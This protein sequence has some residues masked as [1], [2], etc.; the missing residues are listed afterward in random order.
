MEIANTYILHIDHK[1]FKRSIIH[2]IN[3]LNNA[4]YTFRMINTNFLLNARMFA[5]NILLF[6]DT[7]SDWFQTQTMLITTFLFRGTN[8]IWKCFVRT[9][10]YV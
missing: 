4:Y 3:K 6:L 5:I 1:I 2:Y 10:Y 7:F 9:R 8:E